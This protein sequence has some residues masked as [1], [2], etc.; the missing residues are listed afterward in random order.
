MRRSGVR[1]QVLDAVKAAPGGISR[2]K[3]LETM[4]AKGDKAAEQSVSNA[5]AALKRAG[6]ISLVDSLYRA[7]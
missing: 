4:A 7:K 2:A 1:E 3:V 5:L 6:A